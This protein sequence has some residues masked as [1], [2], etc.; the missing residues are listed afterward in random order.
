MNSLLSTYI[1]QVNSKSGHE[2]RNNYAEMCERESQELIY[3]V[4]N[5]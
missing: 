4:L 2:K 1:R 3:I 5:N